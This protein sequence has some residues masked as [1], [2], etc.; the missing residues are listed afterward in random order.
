MISTAQLK[1]ERKDAK[2]LREMAA[3]QKGSI[4]K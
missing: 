4:G 3:L 1:R 2:R